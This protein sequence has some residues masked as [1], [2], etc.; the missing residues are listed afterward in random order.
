MTREEV[1]QFLL[2]LYRGSQEQSI[3]LF[4]QWT[5][6][7]LALVAPF[8]WACWSYG[9]VEEDVC[10]IHGALPYRRLHSDDNTLQACDILP[11][12]T[13]IS[14]VIISVITIIVVYILL[15]LVIIL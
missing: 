8:N 4:R 6:E 9:I 14:L 13:T 3:E 2:T 1:S 11:Q 10:H 7:Q 12:A 5:L 15:L